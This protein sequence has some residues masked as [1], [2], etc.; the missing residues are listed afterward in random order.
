MLSACVQLLPGAGRWLRGRPAWA[1]GERLPA[2][3]VAALPTPA[4][5][6]AVPP[7]GRRVLSRLSVQGNNCALKRLYIT[8]ITVTACSEFTVKV[9]TSENSSRASSCGRSPRALFKESRGQG[10]QC[11][12]DGP[13][14]QHRAASA[15]QGTARRRRR[16]RG[17]P[18]ERPARRARRVAVAEAGVRAARRPPAALLTCRAHPP[19]GPLLGFRLT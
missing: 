18:E 6:P 8:F 12:Q 10:E 5:P 9:T 14:A 7:R 2:D 17:A 16:S 4:P 15:L 11:L 13:A 19:A 1:A 3:V